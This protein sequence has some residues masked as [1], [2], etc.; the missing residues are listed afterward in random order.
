MKCQ[1]WPESHIYH[2][3]SHVALP[4]AAFVKIVVGVGGRVASRKSVPL[5]VCVCVRARARACVCVCVCV[6]RRECVLCLLCVCSML[7]HSLLC[8]VF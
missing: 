7:E 3:L 8:F 4:L 2:V 6:C 5:C 1:P